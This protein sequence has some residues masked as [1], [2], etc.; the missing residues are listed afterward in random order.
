MSEIALEQAKSILISFMTDM[1][2]WEVKYHKLYSEDVLKYCATAKI[3]LQQIYN[4]WLTPKKRIT[5]RLS[6]PNVGCPPEYDPQTELIEKLEE[7]EK[8]KLIIYTN[9]EQI[10]GFK[11]QFRYTIKNYKSEW[12]IDK[13][14]RYSVV[15]KRWE[16]IVF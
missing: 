14:E 16:N 9:S 8:N 6:G 1:N 13:K 2:A 11:E 7:N 4:T 12:K 5:G 3:D 15:N 10:P